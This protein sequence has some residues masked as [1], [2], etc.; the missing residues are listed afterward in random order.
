MATSKLN[1]DYKLQ[2]KLLMED[3]REFQGKG[4]TERSMKMKNI[5]KKD[6]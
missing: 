2:L 5:M 3:K 1:S 6:H 4:E